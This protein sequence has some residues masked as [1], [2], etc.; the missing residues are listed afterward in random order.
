MGYL[1][2]QLGFQ[3][4]AMPGQLLQEGDKIGIRK[5]MITALQLAQYID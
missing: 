5:R 4:A 2:H 3:S 1:V